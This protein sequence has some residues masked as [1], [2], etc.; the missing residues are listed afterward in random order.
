MAEG[1][2][3]NAYVGRKENK[4]NDEREVIDGGEGAEDDDGNRKGRN[5]EDAK[6]EKSILLT[7][8]CCVKNSVMNKF[9]NENNYADEDEGIWKTGR[10]EE[11]SAPAG[12][13][14]AGTD[15]R[16]I[17]AGWERIEKK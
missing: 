13:K 12:W 11:T 6:D 10:K 14:N 8:V 4:E 5:K 16:G 15:D 9:G 7:W 17:S 2:D 3:A 1:N